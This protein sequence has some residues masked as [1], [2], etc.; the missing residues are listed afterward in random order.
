[1]T[2]KPSL[3]NFGAMLSGQQTVHAAPYVPVNVNVGPGGPSQMAGVTP[4][5]T[6]ADVPSGFVGT[7]PEP[8]T[9]PTVGSIVVTPSA[10]SRG[11]SG[12]SSAMPAVETD[13]S[14][15]PGGNSGP[16]AASSSSTSPA[17]QAQTTGAAAKAAT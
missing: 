17:L 2:A 5:A 16:L 7:A 13:T 12:G 4:L 6:S 10:L 9:N 8:P 15:A 1:M 3:M 11:S 14:A